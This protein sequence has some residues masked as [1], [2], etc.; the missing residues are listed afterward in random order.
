MSVDELLA[1]IRQ[2]PELV[3]FDEVMQ[4]LNDHYEY[5]PTRFTNGALVNEAG[6]NEGSC[7]IF[8]F[9]R[10]H[11]LDKAQ[12]LACFGKFYR[13]DVLKQPE[14]TGHQNIRMF[15]LHGWDGI[16]FDGSALR[17]G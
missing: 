14:G 8:A 6:E 3:D 5:T 9:G 13:D 1:K 17:P 15:M 16:T 11:D 10:M 12:T 4:V 7:K 2:T